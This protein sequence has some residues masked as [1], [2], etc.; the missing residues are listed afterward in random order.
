MLNFKTIHISMKIKKIGII[1]RTYFKWYNLKFLISKD[2]LNISLN[3]DLFP[4]QFVNSSFRI[5]ILFII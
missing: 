5:N 1:R 4:K 3:E 2:G